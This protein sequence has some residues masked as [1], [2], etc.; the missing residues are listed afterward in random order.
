MTSQLRF[1]VNKNKKQRK[2]YSEHSSIWVQ[3]VLVQISETDFWYKDILF[4]I[5]W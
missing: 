5:H 1:W 4:Y 3:I 2:L